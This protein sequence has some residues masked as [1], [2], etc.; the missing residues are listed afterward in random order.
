MEERKRK[1]YPSDMTDE[2]WEE[3]TPLY[4][5]MRNCRWSKRELTRKNEKQKDV[6][7]RDTF[8]FDLKGQ[9]DLDIDI[10]EKIKPHQWENSLG[11]G[12]I[13]YAFWAQS[14]SE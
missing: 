1:S 8:V 5:G 13:T 11:A 12:G 2:Q 6:G 4:S 10:S 14:F 9:F 3:I 7:Y